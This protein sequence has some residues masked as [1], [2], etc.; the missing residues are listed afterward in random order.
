[1]RNSRQFEQ[2][3]SLIQ[4][5]V[6][7]IEENISDEVN[8]ASLAKQMAIS[9]WHFQ[10]LFKSLVG[11]T[12]GNYLRARRLTIAADLLLHSQ[13]S[14]IDIALAVGFNSHEAFSR[15][16]KTHFAQTPKDYRLQQ[17]PI[18]FKQKPIISEQLYSHMQ[19]DL[20][21]QPEIMTQEKF[22]IIGFDCLIPSPFLAGDSYCHLLEQVWY[23]LLS[24]LEQINSPQ[25]S[26]SYGLHI[27]PSGN[28]DEQEISYL[29]G[30]KFD[31]PQQ[32]ILNSRQFQ[33]KQ[34]QVAVFNVSAVDEFSVGKT[35]DYIYG[36]WLP[37]SDYKRGRG[38]DYEII[39]NVSDMTMEELSSQYVIPIEK[40]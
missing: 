2:N 24:N 37:N 26:V 27:S 40:K 22:S 16:F 15:S 35:M 18:C 14:V 8:I 38:H 5:L 20:D 39:H 3:L 9:P 11:E 28:Y 25:P 21:C 31:L 36:F 34:Q 7:H 13:R 6:N 30:F 12:L 32:D 1:M 19:Q 23:N 10:R 17:N 29:A 33:F 4:Q